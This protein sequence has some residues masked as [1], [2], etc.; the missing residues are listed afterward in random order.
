MRNYIPEDYHYLPESA[1]SVFKGELFEVFQWPETLFDGSTA[2]FEAIR[3]DDTVIIYAFKGDKIII[4]RQKQPD[5]NH[6]YYS[7]PGGR[8]DHPDE[9][10]ETAAR[11]EL[12][13][14]TGLKFKNWKL[15][16]A[17]QP[18]HKIDY[19]VYYFVATDLEKETERHLDPGEIIEPLEVTL[20]ELLQLKGQPGTEYLHLDQFEKLKSFDDIKN[21]PDIRVKTPSNSSD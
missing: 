16:T 14:E 3:R 12:Q 17:R 7:L 18:E 15:I 11:R 13:E 21:L 19:L 10:E 8:H 4:E 1:K 2:T 6:W 9:D 5:R 20:E